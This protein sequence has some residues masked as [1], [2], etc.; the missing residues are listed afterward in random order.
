MRPVFIKVKGINDYGYVT[1]NAS[2]VTHMEH[3]NNGDVDMFLVGGNYVPLSREG[4]E[5]FMRTLSEVVK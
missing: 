3:H 5:E 4:Y 1:V 2:L